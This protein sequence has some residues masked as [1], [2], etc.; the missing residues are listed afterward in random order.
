MEEKGDIDFLKQLVESLEKAIQNL[1]EFYEKKD[2][3][4]FDKTKKF[5]IQIQNKILE[6]VKV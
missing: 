4:N 2:Y 6:L 3:E 5:I 1:E